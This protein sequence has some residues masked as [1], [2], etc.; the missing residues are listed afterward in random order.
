[1]YVPSHFADPTPLDTF[2]TLV[3]AFPLGILCTHGA[4][5]FDANHVPFH[6]H[7]GDSEWGVLRTHVA[8][9]NPVWQ[10]VSDGDEVMVIFQ[11]PD[12]YISPNW[13]PSK[14]E[15]PRHVPT[16]NYVVA[17][18]HGRI[19]VHDDETY[20]RGVV[21]QLTRDREASEVHP[22]RMAD[23]PPEYLAAMLKAIVGLEVRVERLVT[24]L[25]LGQNRELRDIHGAADALKL[26]GQDA[27]ADAMLAGNI[28]R[29]G[30]R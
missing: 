8:R 26:R 25:K 10:H 16:W 1:M 17:H 18:A 22:W 12:G 29:N 13:Y 27:L 14:L 2:H 20:V 28:V 5:G 21:G 4:G 9:A 11:G 30:G 3:T 15:N 6:L 7:Q 19:T 24:K 23:A